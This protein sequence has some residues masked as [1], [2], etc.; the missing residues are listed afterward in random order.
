MPENCDI[1]VRTPTHT[2]LSPARSLPDATASIHI[3]FVLL[4]L[5]WIRLSSTPVFQTALLMPSP[6]G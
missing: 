4:E 3:L 2:S 1:H 6:S 5:L